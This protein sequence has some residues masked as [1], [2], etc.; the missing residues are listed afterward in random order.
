MRVD[1]AV[2]RY[3][4]FDDLLAMRRVAVRPKDVRRLAELERLRRGM[5][6]P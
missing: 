5:G 6:A 4:A 1:G 2:I 3:L